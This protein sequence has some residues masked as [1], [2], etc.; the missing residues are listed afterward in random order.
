MEKKIQAKH[1]EDETILAIMRKAT[2][3]A[4]WTQ[5]WDFEK[6]LPNI[7]IKVVQAKLSSMGKR[8]IIDGCFCGCRGDF[9]IL[10]DTNA[11]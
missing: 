4:K 5:I 11:K 6:E 9:T 2:N 3:P 10:K 8:G 1:I 7:P